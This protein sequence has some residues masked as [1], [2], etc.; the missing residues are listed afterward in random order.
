MLRLAFLVLSVACLLAGCERSL[1]PAPTVGP[2]A[3]E[4]ALAAA[5]EY[6]SREDLTSAE[7]I[8]R[9]LIDK[10][11]QESRAHELMGRLLFL[12]AREAGSGGDQ[13]AARPLLESAYRHYRAAVEHSK[14]FDPKLTA[15]LNQSAGEIASVAGLPVAALEHFQRA[16]R[17]DPTNPKH[18]LYEAQMLM[19]AGRFPEAAESLKRVLQLDPDEAFAHASL[20][21]VALQENEPH[22]AIEY[23]EEARRINPQT[24]TLRVQEA[25][26]RRLCD[27]PRRGLE[28]L[29]GLADPTRAGEAV[30][31]EI[32]ECYR[33]L[34]DPG[35]AASAWE[36]R[37]RLFPQEWAAAV[38]AAEAHLEAGHPQ[39]ARL[40][41]QE[42][43]RV[44]PDS[45]EVRSLAESLD[46]LPE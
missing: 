36:H 18:P 17:L 15:G 13:E 32:A 33:K 5:Q 29:L 26:I 30:S 38:K 11:P 42:A 16:R 37:F 23:I 31:Y 43:T 1:P 27:Q 21:T 6:L 19:L 25:K 9:V 3:I 12:E 39:E 7:A 14:E 45:Q 44:A 22:K 41:Y 20:A 40:W 2:Q 10:A 4:D 28:L 8:L 24:L 35:S 46:P 34:G